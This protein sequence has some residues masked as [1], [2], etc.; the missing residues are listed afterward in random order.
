MKAAIGPMPADLVELG[1]VVGAYGLRG[2]IKVEPYSAQADVLLRVRNWWLKRDGPDQAEQVR[3]LNSRPQGT[4]VV[5]HPE[6]CHDRD[7]AAA[8]RGYR[9]WVARAEFPAPAT[10]EYYWVDLIGC[11]LYGKDGDAP[12]LLGR[13]TDVADNGAHAVLQV[14][15]LSPAPDDGELQP[16]L[17]AK[18]RE[19]E[20][21]VPFVQAYVQNVDLPA[22][23]IDTDWP[24]DL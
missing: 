15:R 9:V 13:V 22:R 19:Q 4:T 10:D 24:V 17:D 21:L 7:R 2:W 3:I 23:R 16:L 11:L 18:G 20:V 5:A 14:V 6:G 1:R 12:V 8:L